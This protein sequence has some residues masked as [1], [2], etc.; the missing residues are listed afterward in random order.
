MS[1]DTKNFRS[2][3]PARR[4]TDNVVVLSVVA[5]PEAR[6]QHRESVGIPAPNIK[7]W[8]AKHKRAVVEAIHYGYLTLPEA[9]QR[10]ALSVEEFRNWER[11]FEKE[12]GRREKTRT[13][14]FPKRDASSRS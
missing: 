8:T 14:T 5:A 10:Y 2:Q 3:D 4:P 13:L 1:E 6:I 12:D 7:R 9:C 11:T